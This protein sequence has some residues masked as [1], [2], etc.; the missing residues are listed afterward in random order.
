[1]KIAAAVKENRPDAVI[2]EVFE[3]A[4]GLLIIETDTMTADA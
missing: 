3:D 1:M 2:T 4:A